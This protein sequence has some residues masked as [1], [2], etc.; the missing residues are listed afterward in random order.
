MRPVME[1]LEKARRLSKIQ[2]IG[3]SNFSVEHMELVSEVGTIN[4]HQ[5]CYNLLWRYPERDLIPYCLEHDIAVVTYSSLAQGILAGEFSR[6]PRFKDGDQ[7][8]T[9]VFFDPDVW[10]YV[11]EAVEQLK[12][13]AQELERPLAHLAIRWVAQQPGVTSVLVGARN[14]AE[15]REN[16]AAMSSDIPQEVFDRM[17]EISD[18]VTPFI[19]DVGNIFRYYP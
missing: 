3:V 10:P 15:V 11:Y 8:S 18:Q 7:R 6:H 9:T 2:A 16:A 1:G 19:P 14:A 13:L 12:T 5:L 17:T 4:A